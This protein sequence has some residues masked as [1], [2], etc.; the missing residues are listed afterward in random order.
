LLAVK[1]D[2]GDE[3]VPLRAVPSIG[4]LR[5]PS[6][7]QGASSKR[8]VGEGT[9]DKQRAAVDPHVEEHLEMETEEAISKVDALADAVQGWR[10]KDMSG[11]GAA[12][13]VVRA[14]LLDLRN[15]LAATAGHSGYAYAGG[16]AK[17]K[18]TGRAA[19]DIPAKRAKGIN[20]RV[21]HA[22]VD[23]VN[24]IGNG[25]KRGYQPTRPDPSADDHGSGNDGDSVSEDERED[26]ER[27]LETR[28]KPRKVYQL[29]VR[30]RVEIDTTRFDGDDPDSYSKG[31]P[32]VMEGTIIDKKPGGGVVAVR[33]HDGDVTDSHWSHLRS[34]GLKATVEAMLMAAECMGVYASMWLWREMA[35]YQ[36]RQWM[37]RRMWL[38][39]ETFSSAYFA[40]IRSIGWRAYGE[41]RKAGTRMVPTRASTSTTA[42]TTIRSW[43]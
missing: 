16:A 12:Q 14:K 3:E 43:S 2:D 19:E 22:E 30:A 1:G 33:W 15:D 41:R 34:K 39:R 37:W 10:K 8:G 11:G 38:R 40:T 28:K 18:S 6:K 9:T 21:T 35:Y 20:K 31:K 42:L 17:R 29:P 7:Q 36:R 25:E 27:L 4:E 26:E 5:R 24:I 13:G 23:D 32:A